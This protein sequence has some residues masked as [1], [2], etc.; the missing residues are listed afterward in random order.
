MIVC[1][2]SC[3]AASACAAKLA[4]QK[5][6]KENV[7]VVNNP[8]INE[9]GDNQRFL[10]D[11]EDWLGVKID[12]AI[13]PCFPDCDINK[14]YEEYRMMSTP[15]FAPCTL[16]LKQVARASWESA[17]KFDKEK[18]IIVLGY[19]SEETKRRDRFN[20]SKKNKGY[21]LWCPLIDAG[22]DKHR[23]FNEIEMAGIK[24]PAIYTDFEFPNANCIGCVKSGSV[25]YWQ[26]VKKHFPDIFKQRAEQS[27]KYGCRLVE[28]FNKGKIEHLF[29]DEL[30]DDMIGR[31]PKDCYIECGI[32]CTMGQPDDNKGEE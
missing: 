31:K 5:Y 17:N 28:R 32:F 8:V 16:E 10:K 25:W 29:L 19:T 4:I 2:F 20:A 22:W 3:G 18:D 6:G 21:N 7:R 13:N 15:H 23:C 9:H 11:C 27:R 14:V 1:W 24:L 12:K 30:T 26:L